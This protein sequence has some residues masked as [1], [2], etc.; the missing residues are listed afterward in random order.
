MNI[1][2]RLKTV[3]EKHKMSQRDLA[4]A[5]GLTESAVSLYLS[6]KRL[7]RSPAL[8]AMARA[9]DVSIDYLVADPAGDNEAIGVKKIKATLEK[10]ASTLSVNEL[11]K[12]IRVLVMFS[13]G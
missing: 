8:A 12:L 2:G 6:G 9:L 13:K 10:Y 1:A 7:P 11:M 4:R 3:L 5:S